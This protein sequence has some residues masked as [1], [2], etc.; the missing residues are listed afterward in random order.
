MECKKCHKHYHPRSCLS[1]PLGTLTRIKQLTD[2]KTL[3][4]S[5]VL[6]YNWECSACKSCQKC[7]SVDT[8]KGKLLVCKM[9]DRGTH[10]NCVDAKLPISNAYL[11]LSCLTLAQSMQ[12]AMRKDSQLVPLQPKV[13]TVPTIPKTTLNQNNSA[14]FASETTNSTGNNG[15]GSK[16]TEKERNTPG[17]SSV[18][19][20]DAKKPKP[21]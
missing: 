13:P 5:Q 3:Q 21:N 19:V 15:V 11:C 12:K 17:S 16:D 4:N 14:P 1:M 20:P 9:C 8:T 2:P 7:G 6:N 18:F 10:E